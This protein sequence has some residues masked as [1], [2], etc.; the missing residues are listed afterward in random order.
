MKLTALGLAS[1]LLLTGCGSSLSLE[2]QEKLIRYEN[3]LASE[4]EL[5]KVVARDTPA[6]SMYEFWIEGHKDG[7]TL[8][9]S[10]VEYCAFRVP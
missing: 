8:S 5:W 4:L 9:D 10:F 2:E 6:S 1:L 7:K 3:C